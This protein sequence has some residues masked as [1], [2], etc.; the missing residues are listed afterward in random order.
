MKYGGNADYFIDGEML[1]FGTKYLWRGV[2]VQD[3]PNLA[4]VQGYTKASWTLG[5]DATA[6]MVVRM[7]KHLE[8]N[9]LTSATPRIPKVDMVAITSAPGVM[10]L[11]SNYIL[12]AL[13]R[14]PKT[15]DIAPWKARGNYLKDIFDAKYSAIGKG[16]QFVKE[17]S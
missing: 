8:R 15:S 1:D 6:H 3:V 4:L 2:M 10:G 14:L 7:F 13:H 5:A 16:I 17:V 9:K 12:T 11:T